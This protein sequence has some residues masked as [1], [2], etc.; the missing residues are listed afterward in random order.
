MIHILLIEDDQ[1]ISEYIKL[2]LTYEKYLVTEVYDGLEAMEKIK[3]SVYDLIIL[4]LMLPTMSG[5]ELCKE[6]REL[7]DVPIIVVSAK[8]SIT[9]KVE[10]LD[11]GA[12]DY[13]TKPFII[14]ELLARM[15]V[16]L[17]NKKNYSSKKLLQYKDII[18]HKNEKKVF[19]NKV[20]ISFSKTEFK[21]LENLMINSEIV[22]TR[23]Q[24]LDNVWGYDYIG[25]EKIVDVYIKALRSKID[26]PF[27]SK[28]IQTV[29]GFG[30][31]LKEVKE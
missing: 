17:R 9:S 3:S 14:E 26:D 1:K 27:E 29:R 10:M 8:D 16:V 13:I 5:E 7:S 24:I 22:L 31:T 19:R 2:E 30:Y 11:L 20:E 18:L 15:R 25:G 28:L 6:I 21:L 23:E 12:D 4:D